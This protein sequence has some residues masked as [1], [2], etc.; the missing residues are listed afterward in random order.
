[1]RTRLLFQEDSYLKTFEARVVRV[2]GNQ[3]FLDATAFHPAPHGGLDSDVGFLEAEGRAF[4]VVRAELVGDEVAHIVEDPSGLR[5][6]VTAIG[7]I[8]WERRYNMMRLHTAAHVLAAVL[9]EKYGALITGGHITPEYSR[10]DFDLGTE[11]WRTALE[12]GVR[13]TNEIIAR[14]AE[15]KVYW[16]ER[17]RAFSM[18]GMV[19]LA[20]RAP[21]DQERLRVV[22]ITGVDVQL[23]GGP[24]V[25]NTCEIGEIVLLKVENRGKR[26]KRV[27]YTLK[28]LVG[29]VKL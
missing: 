2:E 15:V 18:P 28:E 24:H 23:D 11:E 25:K 7:R 12:I 9:Y 20:E 27:Y 10:D 26:K 8:D 22:E 19:K 21:P 6:G 3:V 14:C 16:L 29:S 5:E 13:K 1:M 17:E 4:R